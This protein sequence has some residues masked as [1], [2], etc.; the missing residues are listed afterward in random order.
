MKNKQIEYFWPFSSDKVF[1][2]CF[3]LCILQAISYIDLYDTLQFNVIFKKNP[4]SKMH[5]K[6][7]FNPNI[8]KLFKIMPYSGFFLAAI[9]PF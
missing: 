2:T 8:L 7:M 4:A 9:Y 5:L 1:E 6:L 3:F